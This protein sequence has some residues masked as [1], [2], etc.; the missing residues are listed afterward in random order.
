M[1]NNNYNNYKSINFKLRSEKSD[2]DLKPLISTT[3]TNSLLRRTRKISSDLQKSRPLKRAS[4]LTYRVFTPTQMVMPDDPPRNQNILTESTKQQIRERQNPSPSYVNKIKK[5]FGS[6]RRTSSSLS[7]NYISAQASSSSSS[8]ASLIEPF[9]SENFTVNK[10]VSPPSSPIDGSENESDEFDTSCFSHS[11]ISDT[12]NTSFQFSNVSSSCETSPTISNKRIPKYEPFFN[13]FVNK[14][15]L[16]DVDIDDDYNNHLNTFGEILETDFNFIKKTHPIFEIPEI[17]EII[18]RHVAHDYTD[19]IPTEPKLIRR[20]PLS[21]NHSLI[22]YGEEKGKQIWKRTVSNSSETSISNSNT[23]SNSNP[24]SI[25]KKNP[26][27]Y[28]F[29]FVNKQWYLTMLSILNENL[30]FNTDSQFENYTSALCTSNPVT[31][32]PFSLVLH[33]IK[34][35]QSIVDIFSNHISSRRLKWLEFYICPTILPPLNFISSSL[36]KLVLP[37]CRSLNDDHLKSLIMKTPE[38]VHLDIRACDQITDASLYFIANNCSKLE[39][40]N[41]GRHTRGELISD[42]SIGYIARNCPIRT[43]GLAGCGISD[44][45][46]WELALHCGSNLERLSLNYCQK[47]SDVGICRVLKAGLIENLSVLEIR[48]LNLK[49]L[50]EIANWKKRRSNQGYKVLV[51][52]CEVIDKMIREVEIAINLEINNRMVTDINQWL[53][54]S[55]DENEDG[56]VD[57]RQFLSDRRRMVQS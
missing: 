39:L 42:A 38:L 51:E 34:S 11:S 9:K 25:I 36:K 14:D 20:P 10:L 8:L 4:S 15:I 12:R 57:Y 55:D 27:L 1:D 40:L 22:I 16:L 35:P 47:L 33:K 7:E 6:L 37:G 2:S 31:P 41:C 21:Y 49:D 19:N 24:N 43:I 29:L 52:A 56:D 5:R 48:G 44:W 17:L 3:A 13:N 28:N 30:Y 54:V 23:N 46:I 53:E 32:E 18:L 26:N 45:A 50:R